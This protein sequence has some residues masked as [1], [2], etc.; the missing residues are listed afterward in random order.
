MINLIK[1]DLYRLFKS[2]T[3]KNC[4]I[5]SI[6]IIVVILGLSV[7]S[8]AELW[9][10]SFVGKEGIRQGFLIG[11]E[12]SSNFKELIINALGSGAGVYIITITLTSSVIIS[13]ARS[14]VMKNTVS[15]GYERWRIYLSQV[16][17]L[18]V[19]ICILIS[20][21]YSIILFV[22]YLTFRPNIN[23]EL[24]LLAVKSLILYMSIASTTVSIYTFLATMISNSEVISVIAMSEIM[25]LSM[26]GVYL[27]QSINNW[28][29]Y[30]M[31]RT[32]AQVPESIE[33]I[34][35]LLHGLIIASV[36]ICLGILVFN[37]K[38]IR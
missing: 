25:G 2:K 37:K 8:D 30:S 34:P 17:S 13:K 26:I 36:S 24:A 32:L 31:I 28:I 7:F 33:L 23:I 20:A 19:A 29:P 18:I 22:T 9:I 12:N 11:I 5:G 35:Y 4:V 21:T 15:Y 16:I 27:P 6:G 38:E 3:F 10:M 14:G 1:S